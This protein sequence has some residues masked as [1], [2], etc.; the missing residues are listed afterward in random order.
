M[1][2]LPALG[3]DNRPA[4]PTAA[5][6]ARAAARASGVQIRQ[7]T[8]LGELRAVY[9]LFDRI[10]RP[11]PSNPPVTAELLRALAKGGNY[12]SGAYEGDRLLGACVGFFS[13]PADRSLHSH[14]AGVAAGAHGR[15]IGFAL[16]L[17]Q[18]A[19]ALRRGIAVITWTY[20]PLVSRNAYFN[21]VK[22]SATPVEYLRNFYGD[23][24]DGINGSD[25]SDRLL[26]RWNLDSPEVAA[27]GLGL[28]GTGA[29]VD[30]ALARGAVPALARSGNGRPA[31]GTLDGEVLLVAVPEDIETL[32]ANHPEHAAQWR[33]AVRDVLG[34]LLADG[35]RVLGF[36]RTAG[37]VV[38]RDTTREDTR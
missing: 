2:D 32:R 8:E 5:E 9:E 31:R 30:A 11:D 25:E 26:I 10:W 18:R 13:A 22:L 4:W 6:A 24:H 21:L 7:L 12:V 36:R 23:M 15:S 20:D 38:T 16:K 3:A 1:T 14:I 37:Y 17:H 28:C 35:A 19:W 29:A 33:A 34:T 27:A